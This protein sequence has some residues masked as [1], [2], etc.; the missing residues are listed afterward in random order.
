[1]TAIS[2]APVAAPRQ[3]NG[4]QTFL[5]G[6][7][8]SVLAW[9]LA[10]AGL[11]YAFAGLVAIT[12]V[13]LLMVVRERERVTMFMGVLSM[14]AIMHKSFSGIEHVSSGPP[15]I[16]VNSV[17]VLVFLLYG[18]WFATG[19]L[20]SDLKEQLR[21][22]VVW[23]PLVA[24]LFTFPSLLVA[25][26][27][28][29]SLAE[30]VRMAMEWL[31][32]VYVAARVRRR[33][34]VWL[35]LSALAVI[36]VIEFL[37]VVGQWVTHSALG[38]SFLGTPQQ[39][40][41]RITDTAVLGR[42]FGTIT[43]P[44][45]M[46]AFLGPLALLGLCLAIHLRN[47]RLRIVSLLLAVLAAAPIAISHA[48]SAAL[49]LAVAVVLVLVASLWG[50]RLELR[51][52]AGWSFAVLIGC[53]VFFGKLLA[54]YHENFHTAHFGVE[55][56]ARGQ[57]Y[58]L[59]WS[60]FDAHPLFGTGLNNFQNV[61]EQYNH[62]GLIFDGNP[63]HNLFL[64]QASETG[65][66][67][68]IALLLAGLPVLVVALRV[69]R[70]RDRLYGAIGMAVAA[71]FA[72][73]I[74]EEM[75]VFSLRQDHP[76]TLFWMLSGLVVAC[77]RLMTQP[78]QLQDAARATAPTSGGPSGAVRRP[79]PR[80]RPVV[81]A[82]KPPRWRTAWGRVSRA[83]GR[84][85]VGGVAVA[86]RTARIAGRVRVA[87]P[88]AGRGLRRAG[89]VLARGLPSSAA[90]G[91]AVVVL[92]A[93]FIVVPGAGSAVDG[94]LPV[95]KI[96][97]TAQDRSTVNPGVLLDQTG[98]YVANSDGSDVHEVVGH[99]GFNYSWSKWALNGTKIVFSAH[100]FG[101]AEPDQLYL[102]N[103]DGTDAQQLTSTQ[104]INGQ[105]SISP[106]G[107]YMLFT[108]TWPEFP[109]FAIYRMDLRTLMVRNISALATTGPATDGDPRYSADGSEIAFA[110]SQKIGSTHVIPTQIWVMNSNGRH[111]VQLTHDKHYNTD[112]ELSPSGQDVVFSSYRGKGKAAEG[113]P[114]Q[115][116]VKLHDWFIVVHN[117]QTGAEY[118]VNQGLEC[119][120]RTD[121]NPC[122]PA[123]GAAY[124]PEWSPDG[125]QISYMSILSA[126]TSCIC[127]T[128]ADGSDPQ[129]LITTTRKIQF[130]DWQTMGAAPSTAAQIG[131]E[132]PPSR[133]LFL[134]STA[135]GETTIYTSRPDRWGSTSITLPPFL[136]L[137]SNPR[138]SV[139]RKHIIFTAQAPVKKVPAPPDAPP[140][141]HRIRHYT[142]GWLSAL[143]MPHGDRTNIDRT[144]TYEMDP[145]GS[146]I[147]VLTTGSTEDWHDAIPDGEWRGNSQGDISPDGRYAVV[148]NLSST[149]S[150]SFLLRINIKSGS[151][152]NLTN[153]TAG[154]VATT[155]FNPRYSPNG[156][157]I[158]FSTI[159]G[160]NS[161]IALIDSKTGR[162]Y[163]PLTDDNYFNIAPTWSPNGRYIVYSS[164]RGTG[165]INIDP[166][167]VANGESLSHLNPNGWYLVRVDT[168]TGHKTVLTSA[169]D[170][171]TFSPVFS[172]DGS[173]IA[174]IGLEHSPAQPDIFVMPAAGG[175]P[176]PL[177]VTLRTKELSLDWR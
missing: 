37:V 176:M 107:R 25:S 42:P 127:V 85:R 34:D 16:Y 48:R 173:Q 65:L 26:S 76:R 162:S 49:G 28:V 150:E 156:R 63:V 44:V 56:D 57:L 89:G 125:H 20:F 47:R 161:Q 137:V 143:I 40:G 41:E 90:G 54:I 136:G 22:P 154:A 61:M 78:E 92:S 21:R 39:L 14:I 102:M 96:V 97:F 144:Q 11:K 132:V 139:D 140:G 4:W 12:F 66:V 111:R 122:G 165:P 27:P 153:A 1:M 80:P 23:L 74:V 93:A 177:Q 64:L 108:S 98:I 145:D 75:F 101:T 33:S 171:P 160:G 72:F 118:S 159:V 15:S 152:Y 43:H 86:K 24:M 175:P 174:Y 141:H 51:V 170:S 157:K 67:G 58:S 3:H 6:G 8:A 29:L 151:V 7:T 45:F 99:N 55:V 70:S 60:M 117:R 169:G 124:V 149:T 30:I 31:V 46:G 82:A 142:L 59:G 88:P 2:D 17:D 146:N 100:R 38:L 115:L 52:F 95:T 91:I 130:Y 129:A 62:L 126:T 120:K 164:Y 133:L 87:G 147:H 84:G 128:Q 168:R 148:T 163:R 103:A 167:K 79:V 18:F 105:P 123:D 113:D 109:K 135:P 81:K 53:A 94:A 131:S 158:A 110:N 83:L 36:V 13:C 68:F 19:T 32:F 73:F 172:P 104:W 10:Q 114:S 9:V 50:R 116:H 138:W 5:L 35:V 77:S 121:A 106:D 119:A 71:M 69:A 155:D 166:V 134:G 112:P